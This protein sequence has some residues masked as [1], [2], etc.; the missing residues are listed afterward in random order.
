MSDKKKSEPNK[1]SD[2]K[3]ATPSGPSAIDTENQQGLSASINLSS[4]SADEKPK[5]Q[6]EKLADTST[7]RKPAI[8]TTSNMSKAPVKKTSA[9]TSPKARDNNAIE[10]KNKLSKTAVVAL[11]I[12]LLAIAASA[13]HYYWN[14][15]QKAQFSQQLSD[16]FQQQLQLNRTKV[17]QQLLQQKKQNNSQLK[18]IEANVQRNTESNIKQLQQQLAQL[19]QQMANLS[20][21]QPSDWLLHEA[22]YLIRVASRSLW[23]EKDTTAAI[24]LLR[25]A[26][27]RIQELNDQQFLSLR[28]TIQQDIASLQLLPKLNTDEVMLKL[29]AL[30]HQSKQLPLAMVNIPSSSE[31]KSDLELTEN[32]SDWRENLAKSWR[33]FTADFI[34]VSRRTGNVE[35]LMSPT[36]Q[37]NLRENLNLKLQTAIWAASKGNTEIYRQSLTDI[38]A[39]LNDYFD[40]A[41][42]SNQHFA[43]ALLVLKNETVNVSYPNKLVSLAVI[44]DILSNN[45]A[46]IAPEPK[47]EVEPAT[48]APAE[49]KLNEEAK[50]EQREDA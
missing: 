13:G 23:L 9:A 45:K 43:E 26:E 29:M 40:M 42:I 2:D 24:G 34:T 10:Q 31:Q 15:Q 17:S 19:E 41:E 50:T 6:D 16:E 18:T 46:P 20:Q 25:D 22:E 37:Q 48:L 5:L 27:R 38:N 32:T 35:P 33:K 8:N 30:A 14:E 47:N 12:A 7:E 3:T 44:R 4:S 11:L 21:S 1:P 39:W 28:Q 36:F 49:E